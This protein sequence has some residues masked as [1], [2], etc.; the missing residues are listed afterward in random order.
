MYTREASTLFMKL[1]E[2]M[3][4][5]QFSDLNQLASQLE[6]MVAD[7]S[8]QRVFDEETIKNFRDAKKPDGTYH[9]RTHDSDLIKNIK[10]LINVIHSMANLNTKLF[11]RLAEYLN[12]NKQSNFKKNVQLINL[13]VALGADKDKL[14]QFHEDIMA[15]YFYIN[16]LT[17]ILPDLP[18][19][20]E[21]VQNKI[22]DLKIAI[23]ETGINQAIGIINIEHENQ[24]IARLDEA[25]PVIDFNELMNAVD[26]VSLKSNLEAIIQMTAEIADQEADSFDRNSERFVTSNDPVKNAFNLARD[27]NKLLNE[28][29]LIILN[30]SNDPLYHFPDLKW[31]DLSDEMRAEYIKLNENIK[32]I[33]SS[34]AALDSA[35]AQHKRLHKINQRNRGNINRQAQLLNN[36]V[37]GPYGQQ[38]DHLSMGVSDA[39]KI[40]GKLADNGLTPE[41]RA[42][43]LIE[44]TGMYKIPA[45]DSADAITPTQRNYMLAHNLSLRAKLTLERINGLQQRSL[46]ANISG[47]FEILQEVGTLVNEFKELN[48]SKELR[49]E[50]LA[51]INGNIHKI[52]AIISPLYHDAVVYAQELEIKMDFR[53]GYLLEK[54]QPI[55]AQIH[56][57]ADRLGEDVGSMIPRYPFQRERRMVLEKNMRECDE[58][59]KM[60]TKIELADLVNILCTPVPAREHLFNIYQ[61]IRQ[62]EAINSYASH[63]YADYLRNYAREFVGADVMDAEIKTHEK[64]I[65]R[66]LAKDGLMSSV[67]L[68]LDDHAN[69]ISAENKKHI[70]ELR[71]LYAVKAQ[72]DAMLASYFSCDDREQIGRLP[73]VM[74][75]IPNPGFLSRVFTRYTKSHLV[76]VPDTNEPHAYNDIAALKKYTDNLK[77][78]IKDNLEFESAVLNKL[79]AMAS[80]ASLDAEDSRVEPELVLHPEA[81]HNLQPA[82]ASPTLTNLNDEEVVKLILDKAKGKIILQSEQARQQLLAQAAKIL[83]PD[84]VALLED[85]GNDGA[86]PICPTDKSLVM[87]VKT[88]HNTMLRAEHLMAHVNRLQHILSGGYYGYRRIPG[89]INKMRDAILQLLESVQETNQAMIML[90]SHFQHGYLDQVY[91][92]ITGIFSQLSTL[93]TQMHHLIQYIPNQLYDVMDESMMKNIQSIARQADQLKLVDEIPASRASDDENWYSAVLDIPSQFLSLLANAPKDTQGFYIL[94]KLPD[95][96]AEKM[97]AALLNATF[98]FTAAL[99]SAGSYAN[100]HPVTGFLATISN[101]YASWSLINEYNFNAVPDEAKRVYEQLYLNMRK[102]L[103]SQ[104]K[105]FLTSKIEAIKDLAARAIFTEKLL[106]VK[107]G[108]LLDN[109]NHMI[110]QFIKMGV[111]EGITEIISIRGD[112]PYARQQLACAQEELDY[113]QANLIADEQPVAIASVKGKEEVERQTGQN[114]KI[115]LQQQANIN[116]IIANMPPVIGNIINPESGSDSADEMQSDD[117]ENQALLP[118]N[119]VQGNS[120]LNAWKIKYLKIACIDYLHYLHEAVTISLQKTY[121]DKDFHVDLKAKFKISPALTEK[122]PQLKLVIDKYNAVH[123]LINSLTRQ[124]DDEGKLLSFDAKLKK[125]RST[126]EKRRDT[127]G[128][129]F[130]KVIVTILSLFTFGAAAIAFSLWKPYGKHAV[131]EMEAIQKSKKINFKASN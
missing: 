88:V 16:K 123:S 58:R 114:D 23:D 65:M 103:N 59:I 45:D 22:A 70:E 116:S 25:I 102:S 94:N 55:D 108:F 104:I 89:L 34:L 18:A 76:I 8:Q 86:F 87:A 67:L 82:P 125:N 17:A 46:T 1:Q 10:L 60:L 98:K 4:V 56:E 63:E 40:I 52:F 6:N 119:Q 39:L 85:T 29:T 120:D 32:Q 68:D 110:D 109:I 64:A 37:T 111:S 96:S 92:Q 93:P 78:D 35:C 113:L 105:Q 36:W 49:Q 131:N 42:R 90:R 11:D 124:L 72:V 31:R 83:S 79:R 3:G 77:A 2:L 107:E 84:Q 118:Q 61:I 50:F 38:I 127:V 19:L 129:T 80:D 71:G 12:S 24:A 13:A 97:I 91:G 33:S 28:S 48:N 81:Q 130:L 66:N 106:G 5:N 115:F 75:F 57:L 44:N 43:Y 95:K 15:F 9:L 27:I 100:H 99:N 53:A 20:S 26:G 73:P 41:I 74:K 7:A 126:L 101:L 21:R 121:P 14:T 62:L 69:N 54:F 30:I 112:F 51:A 122:H 128:I 47:L 117:M